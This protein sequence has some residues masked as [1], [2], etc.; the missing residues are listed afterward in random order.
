M[1]VGAAH[2]GPA[3]HSTD[4][5]SALRAIAQADTSRLDPHKW[6]F[7]PVEAGLVLVRDAEAMRAAFSL[8][9]PCIRQSGRRDLRAALVQ[10]VRLPADPRLPRAQGL[11]DAAAVR[12]ARITG[13][14]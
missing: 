3:I 4:Y 6:L 2:G 8:V 1:H 5:A 14:D 13:G 9:P 7:V 12:A 10:P 11:D